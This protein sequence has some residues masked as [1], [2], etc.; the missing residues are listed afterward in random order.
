MIVELVKVQTEDG[1]RLDGALSSADD[2]SSDS[3]VICLHGV[4]SNFYGSRM[5]GE[6][7]AAIASQGTDCLRVNTRGHDYCY[8]GMSRMGIR[9]LGAGYERVEQCL[10][11]INAWLQWAELRSQ[12]VVLLGHS[13]GALKAVYYQRHQHHE[14]LKRVIAISPPRLSYQAF[15]AGERS[16]EFRQSIENARE[17]IRDGQPERLVDVSVPFPLLITAESYLDKYGEQEKYNLEAMISGLTLTTNF[18]YGGHELESSGIAFSGLDDSIRQIA[19]ETQL[20]QL[21]SVRVI[22]GAD[23]MYS[24]HGSQLIDVV[25]PLI[26]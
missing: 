12:R 9:R 8:T 11:D 5:M 22:D 18:I 21:I 23:H 14:L 25:I 4:G 3:I 16:A 6:L 20:D 10:A 17:A 26:A 15:M 13:L 7:A 1:V 2:V 19:V 24:Q